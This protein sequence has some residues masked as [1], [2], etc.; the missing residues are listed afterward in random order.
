M[1][2]CKTDRFYYNKVYWFTVLDLLLKCNQIIFSPYLITNSSFTGTEIPMGNS[3]NN[4]TP[5]SYFCL[6]ILSW[7]TFLLYNLIHV[8]VWTLLWKM[9]LCFML[10]VIKAQRKSLQ[11]QGRLLQFFLCVTPRPTACPVAPALPRSI[12]GLFVQ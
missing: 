6:V 10:T 2:F 5:A 12:N 9:E 1:R 4:F 8:S 7:I 3:K 11:K